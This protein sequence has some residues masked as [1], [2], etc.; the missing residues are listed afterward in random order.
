[1]TT[2][3][4]IL[5][6]SPTGNPR[7]YYWIHPKCFQDMY[8]KSCNYENILK[9]IKN[10]KTIEDIKQYINRMDAFDAKWNNTEDLMKKMR[11][12]RNPLRDSSKNCIQK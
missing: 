12:L 1:M 6:E 5:C 9:M 4:C 7:E 11:I 10:G 3:Y 2:R 8:D